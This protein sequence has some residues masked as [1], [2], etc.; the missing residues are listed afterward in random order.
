MCCWTR[1]I[2]PNNF[3][4]KDFLAFIVNL[5]KFFIYLHIIYKNYPSCL[6]LSI[7]F[8]N[9]RPVNIQGTLMRLLFLFSTLFLLSAC[10]DTA[11]V[12]TSTAEEK[13][14]TQIQS[15]KTEAQEAQDEYKKLQEQR[16]KE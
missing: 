2:A 14:I 12:P 16:G 1:I 5:L 4:V 13:S 6:Y 8:Y 10:M 3:L 9:P 7:V 11:E 15:N